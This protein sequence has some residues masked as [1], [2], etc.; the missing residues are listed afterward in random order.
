[1]KII[2]LGNWN[3][4]YIVLDKLLQK[5]VPV[6]LV[7]TNYDKNDNDVYKNK[8]YDLAC[9]CGISVYKTYKDILSLVNKGDIAFSIAY[10]SEI[11]KADI[12]DK[13]KIYNFHQIGRASCRERV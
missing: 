6:S 4:G 5:G 9:S 13:I 3:L 11:F 10:G 2:Y 8:V 12:L 7:V 1:M